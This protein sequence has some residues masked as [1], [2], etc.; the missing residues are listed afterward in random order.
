MN[1]LISVAALLAFT[2]SGTAQTA[3]RQATARV[4]EHHP[5][6]TIYYVSLPAPSG[7]V[8]AKALIPDTSEPGDPAVFSLSTLLGSQTGKSV[9]IIP[10]AMELARHGEPAIVV[11]RTLTWP[12]IERTV[13]TMQGAVTCAEQW[14]AKHAAVRPNHWRF[15]G[16]ELDS[17]DLDQFSALGESSVTFLVKFP[18]AAPDESVNTENALRSTS[19]MLKWLLTPFVDGY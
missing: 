19:T 11:E 12:K 15:I 17:P 2:V 16:P 18:L 10:L 8:K 6:F 5:G 7:S 4:L 3:C 9:D 13:G 14:L 1:S